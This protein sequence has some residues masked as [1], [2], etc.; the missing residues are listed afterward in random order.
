MTYTNFP[1]HKVEDAKTEIL[2]NAKSGLQCVINKTCEINVEINGKFVF[3]KNLLYLQHTNSQYK[4]SRKQEINMIYKSRF[5][6]ANMVLQ[7]MK[8]LW[9]NSLKQLEIAYKETHGIWMFQMRNKLKKMSFGC[10]K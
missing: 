1:C 7:Y 5:V 6:S 2:K 8:Q 9:K 10:S 4:Y 3:Q